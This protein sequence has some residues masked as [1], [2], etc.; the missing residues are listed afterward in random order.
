MASLIN[1]I[2][3]K[4]LKFVCGNRTSKG[5]KGSSYTVCFKMCVIKSKATLQVN[6]LSNKLATSKSI[7]LLLFY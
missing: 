4:A 7:H 3:S 1:T 6:K 2:Y 5:A